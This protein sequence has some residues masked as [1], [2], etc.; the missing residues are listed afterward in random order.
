MRNSHLLAIVT[1]QLDIGESDSCT[2]A[3]HWT[4]VKKPHG[5]IGLVSGK[6]YTETSFLPVMLCIESRGFLMFPVHVPLNHSNETTMV[7]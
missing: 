4:A 1:I 3:E 6:L 5:I 2:E 7:E